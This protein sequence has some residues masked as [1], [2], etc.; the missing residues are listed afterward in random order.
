M[1]AA[2]RGCT[3]TVCEVELVQPLALAV[4]TVYIPL[5]FTV[6]DSVVAPFDHR[7]ETKPAPALSATLPPWQNV[8][9]PLGVITGAG[10]GFTVTAANV[11]AEHPLAFAVVTIY[12]PVELTVMDCVVAPFDHRYET[13]PVPASSV[14]LP[15]WQ[16]V[17]GPFGVI[18][19]EGRGNTVTIA[20]VEAEHPPAFAV[21]TV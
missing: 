11:E 10:S 20:K 4:V 7:Y 15:P 3:V 16:K 14:T 8:V 12:V 1:D 9:G 13:K 2:G 5:A 6:I 21:V 18:T 17:V 19:G